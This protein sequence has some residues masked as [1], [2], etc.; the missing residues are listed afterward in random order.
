ML[1]QSRGDRAALDAEPTELS[2]VEIEGDGRDG[3]GLRLTRPDP[4]VAVQEA[5]RRAGG[6]SPPRKEPGI[7][8]LEAHIR[9][10]R[11]V[12]LDHRASRHLRLPHAGES[13][14]DPNRA[15]NEL[16]L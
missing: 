4:A 13:V 14:V 10:E 11:T 7:H 1:P 2:L 6:Q 3:I 5:V 12:R 15:W 8:V 9:R 16:R